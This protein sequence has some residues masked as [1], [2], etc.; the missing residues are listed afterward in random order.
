MEI[1]KKL[2]TPIE[3]QI[4]EGLY[5]SKSPEDVHKN[6]GSEWRLNSLPRA[7]VSKQSS[8]QS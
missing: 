1:L 4:S 8:S 2:E 5:I 7:Y 3:Q 6:S